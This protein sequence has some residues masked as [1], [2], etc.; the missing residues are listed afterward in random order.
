MPVNNPKSKGRRKREE[1][2][3]ARA[4]PDSATAGTSQPHSL[5]HEMLLCVSA[6]REVPPL[7]L[8]TRSS[9]HSFQVCPL[10]HS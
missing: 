9:T 3:D 2:A 5:V 10:M 4:E 1:R 6:F 8:P 7:K